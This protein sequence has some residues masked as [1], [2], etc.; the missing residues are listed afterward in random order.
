MCWSF[1]RKSA[2]ISNRVFPAFGG[3]GDVS[4]HNGR[5]KQ[6]SYKAHLCSG[7]LLDLLI[8]KFS[9]VPSTDAAAA[10]EK[11]WSAAT[12]GGPLSFCGITVIP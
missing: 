10:D 2:V 9:K 8:R 4:E 7:S 11:G 5:G 3:G 12:A 6:M 1:S